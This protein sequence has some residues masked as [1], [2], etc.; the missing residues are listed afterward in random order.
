MGGKF[1]NLQLL[2]G[3]ACLAVVAY[4]VAVMEAG[5]GL[6]QNPLKPLRWFGYAGVDLF[7]VLSGFII[8]TTCRRDLGRP[9]ALPGYLA[10]RLGRVY[11]PY[12]AA[13]V[14]AAASYAFDNPGQLIA[15]SRPG[16][17]VDTLLL[18]P[19]P[20]LPRVMK[21]AWTLS[22]EVMFYLAFAGLFLLPRRLSGPAL[23]AWAVGVVWASGTGFITLNRIV[24]LAVSPF[25]LEF[26]AGCLVA[27]APVA[28]SGR[29]AAGVLTAA[30]MWAGVGSAVLYH[31]DANWLPERT[32]LRVGL[33]GPAATLAVFAAGGWERTGGRWNSPRLVA[34]GDASYS[35]YLI[36][37]PALIAVFDATAWLGWNHTKKLHLAWLVLMFVA[38]VVPGLL[39]HWW[40]ERPLLR[41][42][43][44]RT[45]AVNDP[46]PLGRAA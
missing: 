25:V 22:Y 34:L 28:L 42:V 36:H 5:F 4:H 26:L 30:A 20:P 11:P 41:L 43:R 9:A 45:P 2:R 15:G 31:P 14:F 6:G 7:F 10:R 27:A 23:L 32:L 3:V 12:W 1:Q 35:V 29:A 33:F 18:L 13:L 39:F 40:V 17:L 16:E 44:R 38:G 46:V 8:A 21:A 37:G 19:Q 24:A